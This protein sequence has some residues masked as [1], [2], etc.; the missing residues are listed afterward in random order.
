MPSNRIAQM[1][2]FALVMSTATAVVHAGDREFDAVVGHIKREYHGKKQGGFAL[3]L[4]GFAIR[5]AHPAGVKSL[6]L[7]VFE[8]LSG[9]SDNAGLDAVLR[10]TL[11]EGWTPIVRV[12]SKKE[13]EQTYVYLRPKGD[14]IELFIVSVDGEDATVVKAKVDVD[15]AAD[16]L[17]NANILDSSDN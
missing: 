4:A 16:W 10:D 9:T 1:I 17:A 12:Y 3:G 5:F 6:K 2:V 7:A 15:A 11:A 13:R 8:Q 14:D